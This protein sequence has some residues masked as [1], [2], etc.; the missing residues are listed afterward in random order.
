LRLRLF[1]SLALARAFDGGA[2]R[3][4]LQPYQRALR[5]VE[6]A[7]DLPHWCGQLP[8]QRWNRNYLITR[9][10]LRLLQKVDDF[11]RVLAIEM[12]LAE[13]LQIAEGTDLAV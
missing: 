4:Q 6:I 9:S 2:R 10:Q 8:H 11:D 7:D 13:L 1:H 5:V 12:F 3:P